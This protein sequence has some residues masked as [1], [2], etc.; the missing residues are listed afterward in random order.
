MSKS[1]SDYLS[2][3]GGSLYITPYVDGVLTGNQKDF[4]LTDTVEIETSVSYVEKKNT[5][6]KIPATA[7]KLP[8]EIKATIKFTTGE[9]SP[10][11]IVRAFFGNQYSTTHSA[12]TD[13]TMTIA[14]IEQG[15]KIQTGYRKV[16][17]I[18]VKS[19]DDNTTYVEGTDY[20]MDKNTGI[21]SLVEGSTIADGS[22]LHL[23]V[24]T[25]EYVTT[26]V[27]ALKTSSL[28]AKLVFIS[29]PQSG[30]RYMYTFN[31]VSISASGS[32]ALKSEEFASIDFEGEVLLDDSVSATSDASQ[33][34]DVETL[35]DV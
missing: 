15:D 11:M 19:A 4:G 31:K 35:P 1:G 34:F 33:Y 29:E 26:N 9:I 25:S 22:E 12:K 6:G 17:S 14:T 28:E 20:S 21:F 13:D 30:E 16:T 2:L 5:E 7:K 32:L 10:A 23:T 18:T 24:S 8:S 3:G 27:S